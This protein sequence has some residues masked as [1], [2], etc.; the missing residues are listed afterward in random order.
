[1]GFPQAKKGY[2]LKVGDLVRVTHGSGNG[3]VGVVTSLYQAGNTVLARFPN[4]EH[5]SL[6]RLEVISEG[7]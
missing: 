5:Y 2:Q 7:R 6:Q 1:V 4:G 3:T